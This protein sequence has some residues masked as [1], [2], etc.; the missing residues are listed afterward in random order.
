MHVSGVASI[1]TMLNLSSLLARFYRREGRLPKALS[2]PYELASQTLKV[3][4]KPR[5]SNEESLLETLE[6]TTILGLICYYQIRQSE[7]KGQLNIHLRCK[8][9]TA[10]ALYTN[11]SAS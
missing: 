4:D 1:P 2:L 10:L 5:G 7:A 3:Q 8:R 6:T 11:T 9:I